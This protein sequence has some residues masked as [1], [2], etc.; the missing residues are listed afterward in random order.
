MRQTNGL[1]VS[2][3]GNATLVNDLEEDRR[4]VKESWKGSIWERMAQ[5]GKDGATQA[6]LETTC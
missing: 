6:D 4:D 3:S 1:R 2:P 5:L